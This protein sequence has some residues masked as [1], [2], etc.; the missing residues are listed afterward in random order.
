MFLIVM[1]CIVA[2]LITSHIGW[3]V[4]ALVFI[5]LVTLAAAS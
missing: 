3:I 1:L 2:A 4:A 5:L